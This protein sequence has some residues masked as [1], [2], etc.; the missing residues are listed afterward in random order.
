M[1]KNQEVGDV[2]LKHRVGSSRLVPVFGRKS[3]SQT[4]GNTNCCPS[5]GP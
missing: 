2:S 5:T 4:E 1:S 3:D